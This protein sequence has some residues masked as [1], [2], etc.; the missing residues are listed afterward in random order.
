MQLSRLFLH[1]SGSGPPFEV[2]FDPDIAV[3]P[4]TGTQASRIRFALESLFQGSTGFGRA[5][6][7]IDGV[8][9]E[10]TP[11]L[12]THLA[13]H[14][15]PRGRILEPGFAEQGEPDDD[16][17]GTTG[18]IVL[19]AGLEMVRMVER[20]LDRQ[21]VEGALQAVLAERRTH[22]SEAEVAFTEA[23]ERQLEAQAALDKLVAWRASVEPLHERSVAAR[24]RARRRLRG[25][26]TNRRYA[27]V[28]AEEMEL[29]AAGDFDSYEEFVDYADEA[30]DHYRR[31]L[32]AA[33]V[34]LV[35]A[36]SVRDALADGGSGHPQSDLLTVQEF[37]L[38]LWKATSAS[39]ADLSKADDRSLHN[40]LGVAQVLE[41]GVRPA[42][43]DELL[44][45]AMACLSRLE[46]ER[47]RAELR[48]QAEA[49][50]ESLP[51][52]GT[53]PLVLDGPFLD[54]D[55]D[56]A[57]RVLSSLDPYVGLVQLV[58]VRPDP[59]VIRWASTHRRPETP[60]I[61]SAGGPARNAK[62]PARS[63]RAV[64]TRE[65]R[66]GLDRRT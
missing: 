13:H 44:D 43:G 14:V 27:K 22:Q 51:A 21:E 11:E 3:V 62:R 49:H 24:Q 4:H 52:V 36:A 55:T 8:E 30:S 57:D 29:L 31:E 41:Y 7:R 10:V 34:A 1:G 28:E 63:H 17:R 46:S 25:P 47:L 64:P 26:F 48:R 6:L 54:V 2:S 42:A 32:Q 40:A 61:A 53:V 15:G 45:Q 58:L 12:A 33:E 23:T 35:E 66:A 20:R 19:R 9:I 37:I 50:A 16:R 56:T 5:F 18:V 65:R 38:R 39:A 59:A 60:P